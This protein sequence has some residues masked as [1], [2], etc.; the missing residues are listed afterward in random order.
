MNVP[1]F[2]VEYTTA[3]DPIEY[4]N[5]CYP[6]PDIEYRLTIQLMVDALGNV[7]DGLLALEFGGGPTLYSVAVLAERMREIHFCDY[8]SENL[9]EVQRWLNNDSNAFNWDPFIKV[10]LKERRLPATAAA[11]AQHVAKMRRKVTAVTRCDALSNT[12]LGPNATHYDLVIAQNCTDVAAATIS[13][14][15]QIM[16]NINTLVAPGGWLLV[17]VTTGATINSVGQKS[18]PCVNLSNEDIYQG[19]LDTGY[20]PETFW[21]DTRTISG[22]QEYSGLTCAIAR[23]T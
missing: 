17:G 9:D 15:M 11:I 14:W 2:E 5:E 19:Y 16:H 13:E 12:P 18:F 7:P 21:L 22:T 6:K 20:D 8:V 4:L 10:F 1:G 23:K 3:F